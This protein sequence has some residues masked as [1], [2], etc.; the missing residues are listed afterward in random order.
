MQRILGSRQAAGPIKHI[1]EEVQIGDIDE[2]KQLSLHM[3][4][5]DIDGGRRGPDA[6]HNISLIAGLN[7][8]SF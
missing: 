5:I 8:P 7:V 6:H 3:N 4:D 2:D 1:H